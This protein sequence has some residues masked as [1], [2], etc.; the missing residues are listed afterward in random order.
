MTYLLDTNAISD[1]MKAS[2]GIET[3]ISRFTAEDRAITCPIIR[4]ELLYG[5][6]RLPPG[7]KRSALEAAARRFLD[8]L[9]CEPIPASV[10]DRY[11][12]LRLARQKSGLTLDENDL[13][14][15]ATAL[16]FGATLV[17]RDSDFAGIDSLRLVDLA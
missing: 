17:T 5:I 10:G 7:R 13:W 14:I 2:G 16:A 9:H 3:L 6:A 12:A 15:A 8:L 1:W 4:G 11:A